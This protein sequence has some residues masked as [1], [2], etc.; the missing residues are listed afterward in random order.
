MATEEK[1][2]IKVEVDADI[3]DD[4][5]IIEQRIK[6]LEKRTKAFNKASKDLDKT[7][8]RL[9]SKFGKLK[10]LFGKLTGAFTKFFTTIAK[11]SFLALAGQIGLFT[12]GLLAAKAA[13]MTGRVAVQGYQI[14]LR[15]LSVAAAGV[16]T[17]M[18][19]AAAALREFQEVQLS[20]HLGGGTKGRARAA[21]LNRSMSPKMLGLL[22]GE[23]ASAMK[24]HYARAGVQASSS[25]MLTKQLYNL[26]GGDAKAAEALAASFAAGN[27]QK[28]KKAVSSTAG[29]RADSLDGVST[30][31]GLMSTVGGGGATST[32]FSGVSSDM[33]GT[34]IGTLKT[35]FSGLVNIF[36][37]MGQSM[38][39]PFR[40]AFQEIS[41][42]LKADIIAMSG[43]V[44]TFGADSFAPTLV[45]V[46][47]KV[48]GF[49]RD[50]I[51][52][53]LDDVKNMGESFVG[54]FKQ[55]GT[56]FESIGAYLVKLEPAADVVIEMFKAMGGAAGGR[57]LFQ[58]FNE[59]VTTNGEAFVEFGSAIGNV[60][61][62]LFDQLENGQMG[63]FNKLPLLSEIL[64]TIAGSVIPSVYDVLNR[65]APLMERIPGALEGLANVLGM[66]APLI[67]GLVA[68]VNGIISAVNMVPGVGSSGMGDLLGLAAVGFGYSKLKG[69]RGAAGMVR[70]ARG[71]AG[72]ASAGSRVAGAASAGSRVASYGSGLSRQAR[73]MR[74]GW[75]GGNTLLGRSQGA[76]SG[77]RTAG[78]R[79]AASVPTAA[80]G[81][82]K[83]AKFAKG[84]KLLGPA[85]VAFSAFDLGFTAHEYSQTGENK[86]GGALAGAGL[87]A[88]IGSM[89]APGIGTVAGALIGAAVGEVIGAFAAW[90]GGK[91]KVERSNKALEEIF[92]SQSGMDLRN[93]GIAK[94]TAE[95]DKLAAYT[96]A[97]EA[98]YDDDGNLEMN[99]DTREFRDFMK[100]LGYDPETHNRDKLFESLF[101]G[102]YQEKQEKVLTDATEHLT[103]KLTLIADSLDI[104]TDA[105][106][107][108]ATSLGID[109]FGN[110]N[111]G[112]TAG[113][114]SLAM[115]PDIL[116][117]RSNP[118][119]PDFSSSPAAVDE[120][121]ASAHASLNVLGT[122]MENGVYDPATIQGFVDD[123]AGATVK[124]GDLNPYLAGIS[125]IQE[126]YE[127][128][129]A[130]ELN[131]NFGLDKILKDMFTEIGEDFQLDPTELSA[132]F[133][134]NGQGGGV[135][136]VD[137]FVTG[138]GH[139][140]KNMKEGML[141]GN[142][143][144]FA[145]SNATNGVWDQFLAY[146]DRR[147]RENG[148]E[149]PGGANQTLISD[150][151]AEG[152]P[153]KYENIANALDEVGGTKQVMIDFLTTNDTNADTMNGLLNTIAENTNQPVHLSVSGSMSE[154]RFDNSAT[155][156]F[157]ISASKSPSSSG[158]S[159]GGTKRAIEGSGNG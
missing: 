93:Q 91:A 81:A 19:V 26:T 43:M 134:K 126:L 104:T 84:G 112:I 103:G 158:N 105:V 18:A 76:L 120:L 30:M 106:R 78:V 138:E 83:F 50:N 25:N 73:A 99:G 15:G 67:G 31:G 46:V 143:S 136:S 24:M 63:F 108:F 2:V 40:D 10:S 34:L 150:I 100:M 68:A 32:A 155:V 147:F 29:Y 152:G 16:A 51:M 58:Q 119:L 39:A 123:F 72:A 101:E 14:A 107:E 115:S 57:G 140:R 137:A 146:A 125:S 3:T 20:P 70:G 86:H 109:L 114:M 1:V 17:A 122:E 27:F 37:D 62:A 145:N 36:A 113:L 92:D 157:E 131:K 127:H 135:R 69:M 139:I 8:D 111:E 141:E 130:D 5:K 82:S 129:D 6:A 98:A 44:N 22:G 61:G 45:T 87:G 96:A 28:A 97:V 148:P 144:T 94:F 38:V 153:D 85:G 12:A 13:L 110:F 54:F 79:H 89:I 90:K 151:S 71:A 53:N 7:T 154:T 47:E 49:I 124:S 132:R 66:L 116:A 149:L 156:T 80:S 55:A 121:L 35:S 74:G 117:S 75:R 42:I 23:S 64:N 41:H 9:G 65:F 59:L 52:D 21:Q 11:F 56:F 88:G 142:L 77:A 60:F 95:E 4:L 48:S 128:F 159:S 102:N 118:Y 33:A 133:G